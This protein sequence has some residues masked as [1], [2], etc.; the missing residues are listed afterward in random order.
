MTPPDKCPRCGAEMYSTWGTA[1]E[2]T[3]NSVVESGSETPRNGGSHLCLTRQLAAAQ[4]RVKLL[5]EAAACLRE[6]LLLKVDRCK[7]CQG[8]GQNNDGE[9]LL[10]E[11]C[12]DCEE[13]R[14]ALAL[15]DNKAKEKP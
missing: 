12:P 5:E 10:D 7:N 8:T 14:I 1:T 11:A 4:S 9:G 3:C 6:H 15:Y 13:D 2:Y